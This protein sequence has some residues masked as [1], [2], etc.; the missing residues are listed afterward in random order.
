MIIIKIDTEIELKQIELS[1]SKAIFETIDS[2][3]EYLGKW[4]PFVEFTKEVSDTPRCRT[5]P[6][7]WLHF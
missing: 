3:R 4:L 2:Q 6:I 7:V 1:D 5:N